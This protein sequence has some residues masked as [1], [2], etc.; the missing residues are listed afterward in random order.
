MSTLSK[1]GVA[2]PPSAV[3]IV[4]LQ[5][6]LA[7]IVG[8]NH[9]TQAQTEI[10]GVTPAV[11]I[12]PSSAEEVAAILR[13]ANE[14]DLQVAPAGGCTRQQI[15]G[16]PDRV[17]VLLRTERLNQIRQYDPGDLTVG[18]G[19]GIRL[20][21]LQS[22]MGKHQQWLPYDPPQA[23]LAT[24]GGL[25]ATAAFGPLKSGFGGLRD[26]C[27][28][29]QFV[30]GEGVIAKAGGNVV[31]NVAGYDLMKLMVG[32]YGSLA[33]I[34]GANFKVF[35][36]PRQTRSFICS[37]P[38]LQEAIA[39]RNQVLRSPLTPICLELVSP[40]A[41]EYLCDSPVAHDPDHYAPAGPMSSPLAEWQIAVR[42]AGSDNVLARC[43]RELGAPVVREL[44]GAREEQFWSWVSNFEV[45]ILERHRNA[46]IVYAHATI[47]N[48][49]AV[50]QALEHSA[51]DY[52]F[53]P[54][55]LGRAAT[56][57]LVLGFVPLPVD[58]PAAMQY[59]NCTSAFRALLPAGCSAIVTQC[60]KEAKAYFD[61]WGS[62]PTDL[63][64][65]RGVKRALDPKRILNRGRFIV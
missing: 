1:A 35:P 33:V 49:E 36:R 59:A 44:E 3:D 2:Q 65:M 20:A 46:M 58:P 11:S 25:L 37:L 48:V 54:A 18:V 10:N 57:N 64:L 23:K 52:N 30:T 21:D 43:R 61:V 19:A 16:I 60:P 55:M 56:G 17:D 45:S 7:S 63:D 34:T 13:L 14:R 6:D 50:V 5:R 51:P 40:R 29:I 41:V 27:I 31:K 42:A 38:S 12:A 62:T 8:E 26:F 32:S 15:G 39:F 28:G 53:L 22:A 47:Q 4:S 9:V 24:V